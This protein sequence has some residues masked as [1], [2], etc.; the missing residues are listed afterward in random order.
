MRMFDPREAPPRYAYFDPPAPAASQMSERAFA[1][2]TRAA[3][4]SSATTSISPRCWPSPSSRAA[5]GPLPGVPRPGERR[6]TAGLPADG[7]SQPGPRPD[8]RRL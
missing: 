3:S 6:G 2:R 5:R 7:P 1:V 4:T 8:L